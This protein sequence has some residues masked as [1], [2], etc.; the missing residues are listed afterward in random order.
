MHW[1]QFRTLMGAII[2]HSHYYKLNHIRLQLNVIIKI[3]HTGPSWVQAGDL[4]T[5][6]ALC[7]LSFGSSGPLLLWGAPLLHAMCSWEDCH[8]VP[9]GLLATSPHTPSPMGLSLLPEGL[10]LEQSD[11]GPGLGES[12]AAPR[13]VH[14]GSCRGPFS[15][16]YY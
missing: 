6:P 15:H 4:L 2:Q 13:E 8:L 9:P 1:S 10:T 3:D 7:P 12:G 14:L 11:T 5:F 16:F